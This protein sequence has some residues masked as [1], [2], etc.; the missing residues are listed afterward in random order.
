MS[1]LMGKFPFRPHTNAIHVIKGGKRINSSQPCAE[2]V[3]YI[4][5]TPPFLFT[6]SEPC[7]FK[8]SWRPAQILYFLQQSLILPNSDQAKTHLLIHVTW[9]MVHPQCFYFGK[10]VEIWCYDLNEPI[11]DNSF[12]LVP[13]IVESFIVLMRWK[14]NVC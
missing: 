12:Q 11:V 6:T 5:A 4:L 3:S 8:G 2:N 10:P 9:P 7:E 13:Y 1:S 14:M